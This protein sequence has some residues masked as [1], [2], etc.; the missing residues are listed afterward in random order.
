[1][2]GTDWNKFFTEAFHSEEVQKILNKWFPNDIKRKKFSKEDIESI[3]IQLC[4]RLI[5]ILFE[6]KG[7]SSKKK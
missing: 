4:S 5:K 3:V 6:G 2:I 1:M 7:S